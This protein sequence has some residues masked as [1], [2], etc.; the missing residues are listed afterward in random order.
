MR[1][2]RAAFL[3]AAVL[4]L[5]Y[6]GFYV[7]TQSEEN[8]RVERGHEPW[9]FRSVMDQRP[10]MITLALGTD[11]WVAY[12]ANQVALYK[13][14]RDGVDFDGAVYTTA[15][16]P[17]PT[18]KG[19]AFLVSPGDMPWR[20]REK[21]VKSIPRVQYR[22]HRYEGTQ[23]ILQYE[24]LT[25]SGAVI[26]IEEKPEY[27]HDGVGKPGL[28][29]V[30]TL[31]G[32]P[33]GAQV[34]LEVFLSSVMSEADIH[35][36]AT[37][38]IIEKHET[39]IP[40]THLL[41]LKGLLT[42]SATEPT[43]LTVYFHPEPTVSSTEEE[44]KEEGPLGMQLIAR[45]DCNSCHNEKVKTVG[46]AYVSIAEK[47]AFTSLNVS[48]LAR[49][50]RAGGSGVWGA[51]PMTA[52]PD[53]QQEDAEAMVAYIMELDGETLQKNELSTKSY[54]LI[55]DAAA[56][57]D[58]SGVAVNIYQYGE[59]L[60]GMPVPG[61]DEKPAY[62][63]VAAA[64]HAVEESDFGT[65]EDGF[66]VQF[67]GY[68]D[69][70]KSTNYVFRLASD[71]GS[72]LR[73]DNKVVVDHDGF[74]GPSPKDSEVIL[75]AGKHPFSLDYF[76]AGGGQEVSL[77]WAPY[78]AEAFSVV[79]PSL[80]SHDQ[81]D[82]KEA[83]PFT[84]PAEIA[85]TPGDSAALVGV[86]PAFDVQT[87]RPDAFQPKV[88]GLDFLPDGR[89]VVSTWDPDGSVYLLSNIDQ[90]DPGKIVVKRIALGLA[91]PLGLKVVEGEIYVLQKQ[92]LTQLIDHDGDDFI[93]EYRTVC[94]GWQASANFHEFAFGLVYQDGYFYCTLATAINPGGA[95]TQPQIHDRGRAVKISRETGDFEF[96]AQ[97]LRTPNGIGVG[98]DNELFIADNQGDWL[99]A[100]KILH[101]QEGAF[102]GSRSVDFAGTEGLVESP[103]V[104]WLPQDEIGN[105]PSQPAAL[106]VGPYQGQMIH[107][108]VT[109]GGI[110]RVFVEKVAGEY[111]GCLFRFT[112][113][114][115]GGVNRLVWGPDGA[116]Y[117]GEVGNPGNWGHNGK[118]KYGLQ[119][120]SYTGKSA[121][122][123]L[124]VRAKS[125]GM[126]IEFTEPL[127]AGDGLSPADYLVQQW[128][129]Q[130]T[131]NY[132]GPK[133]D[134]ENLKILSVSRSD[135]GK[136]VFLEL[137]EMK[138]GHV[139]YIH[140]K[141]PLRSTNNQALWTTEAWYT[142]NR[143]PQPP[144]PL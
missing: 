89:L 112:Q 124:A 99:P 26:G 47:Y 39:V 72:V 50:I 78:G 85:H 84:P 83:V 143:I 88:G 7:G 56:P 138:P 15:H 134:K 81:Q 36:N 48:K 64:I 117:I 130:P 128:R 6:Y 55:T 20:V 28:E 45:S 69:I 14:W 122:E 87:I 108:E 137:A 109:H 129:Y 92:E 90:G 27:L 132:G 62:S 120:L 110:K 68:I 19:K 86:H 21:G 46:P 30:F 95:S 63:G 125:N 57:A 3:L 79:P 49:K 94:N 44:S 118:N 13:A 82:L 100:S 65:F 106:N 102:F 144:Q 32:V 60:S 2:D 104:V 10:R 131:E 58:G 66:Y 59:A 139:V 43:D 91:E 8:S 116:L 98:V 53:L 127:Q 136:R 75:A 93:D 52:H 103:P 140:L 17:Q 107:G 67:K 12:D 73:I 119:R 54:P 18:A 115:E 37:F 16:G 70:P 31:S 34:Q 4:L 121:F 1:L 41:D 97:G 24:L 111:Q 135:D 71:D 25:E 77:Q 61:P 114:L 133:L 40:G 29:R 35:T 5:I 76:E 38:E 9:V 113:G 33:K 126:E 22:G 101:L 11:F 105:S 123:M 141:S 142:L 42:F 96:V 80:F 51:V 23:A 74:H